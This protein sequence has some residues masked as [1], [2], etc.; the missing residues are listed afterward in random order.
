MFW[1]KLMWYLYRFVVLQT[2]LSKIINFLKKTN[3][4]DKQKFDIQE[5]SSTLLAIMIFLRGINWQIDQSKSVTDIF[6]I[7]M[8][9][10]NRKS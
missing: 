3:R 10:K 5:N 2:V 8:N 9:I 4:L 6:S 1:K 7:Q